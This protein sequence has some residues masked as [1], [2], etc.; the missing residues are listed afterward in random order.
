MEKQ[1]KIRLFVVAAMVVV[2]LFSL[3]GNSLADDYLGTDW[4]VKVSTESVPWLNGSFTV[5]GYDRWGNHFS[6][7]GNK[8]QIGR[9]PELGVFYVTGSTRLTLSGYN[10][11]SNFY[12]VSMSST[13]APILNGGNIEVSTNGENHLTINIQNSPALGQV[14]T[15]IVFDGVSKATVSNALVAKITSSLQNNGCSEIMSS[16]MVD[17]V[18]HS[19]QPSA[20]AINE[21]F[22]CSEIFGAMGGGT[23]NAPSM[24]IRMPQGLWSGYFQKDSSVNS[25]DD[26]VYLAIDQPVS[27][28]TVEVWDYCAKLNADFSIDIPCVNVGGGFY[29]IRL[30]YANQVDSPLLWRLRDIYPAGNNYN[31]IPIDL[32]LELVIPYINLANGINYGIGLSYS[33]AD[34]AG[35]Y[36]QITSA[37]P[38]AC[39]TQ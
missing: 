6:H 28:Y 26:N 12:P 15:K 36:W 23:L 13:G 33:G 1:R 39:N 32:D 9:G 31:S 21:D 27:N 18:V 7:T 38:N 30:D 4:W 16:Y 2:C 5:A 24:F 22:N 25:S 37:V 35:Y 34:A 17:G 11:G 10:F 19:V 20:Q 29:R 8:I 14:N 3:S